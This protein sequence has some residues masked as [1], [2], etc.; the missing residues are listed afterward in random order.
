L[1]QALE[2]HMQSKLPQ[3]VRF[4]RKICGDLEQAEHREWWLSNG[5]GGYAAGT[6]AGTLTRRYHGLLVAPVD[7]PLGRILAFTKADATLVTDQHRWPLFSNRWTGDLVEPQGHLHIESFRLDGTMPVW[8]YAIGDLRLEARI[9]MRLDANTTCLAY[10]LLPGHSETEELYLWVRLLINARD[11]HGHTRKGDIDPAI[12]AREK[13]LSVTLKETATLRFLTRCGT[14][15][16][17]RFW[18]ENFD[19]P[20]ERERGLPDRDDHLCVGQVSLPLSVGEWVGFVATL[21]DE[22]PL[23]YGEAIEHRQQHDRQL[24]IQAKVQSAEC[25]RAPPWI[26]QLLLAAGSFLIARPL[27][28]VPNGE[29]I[30][31]GY[32]WFG[33][34]GRDAMIALPGLTLCTHRFEQA[35]HILEAYSHFVDGGMLPN[36]FPGNGA[37]AEYNTA[38][39]ALWFIEAW[40]AYVAAS[41]DHDTVRQHFRILAGIID[42]YTCGTRYGIG[43]DPLDGLLQAGEPGVQVT[44]MDAKLGDWVVTPRIGKAVERNALWHNALMTMAELSV[45]VGG[46]SDPYLTAATR[47]RDSF[48]RFVKEGGEGLLDV[49]DGPDG[50]DPS[51]RPNQI[52]AVSLTHSPLDPADQAAVIKTVDRKLLTSCGLRSLEPG[53]PDYQPRYQGGVRERDAAYHQG[54]VWTWLL[55]HYAL[56][57]YRVTGD[58]ALAQSYLE[59]LENHLL[60]AGLGTLGEIFDGEPPHRPRG[61]PAQAWSVACTLEAWCHLEQAKNGG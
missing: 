6:L 33:D 21:D 29:S 47:V 41:G 40:R 20:L 9:W 1:Q 4:G 5:L 19:L 61:T 57:V 7:P 59:P 46:E 35:R 27:P 45:L 49:I 51:L 13:E 39:A 60:D 16:P 53:H 48:R 11:H 31:A 28:Q 44:W 24:L 34:W 30:I 55:G 22:P 3:I 23:Y 26:D 37:K 42:A 52:L 2:I 56:A 18:V 43:V 36:Y 14:M 38:D 12:E 58:A 32:P 25:Q 17:E 54:P 8:R 15:H 50:D 10:Q